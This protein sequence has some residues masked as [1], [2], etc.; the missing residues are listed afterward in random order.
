MGSVILVSDG[1]LDKI[2]EKDICALA[3]ESKL[4][5]PRKVRTKEPDSAIPLS[6]ET[7]RS[8]IPMPSCSPLR[9]GIDPDIEK[10]L[11][12]VALRFVS[13]QDTHATLRTPWMH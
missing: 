8:D 7:L 11:L 4:Q 13:R 2:S 10:E 9:L 5:C 6:G 3:E 12:G 1:I